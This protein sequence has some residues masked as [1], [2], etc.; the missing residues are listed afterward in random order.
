MTV[1]E[2]LVQLQGADPN[3]IVVV[4]EGKY[5]YKVA[6][7]VTPGYFTGMAGDWQPDD[8]EVGGTNSVCIA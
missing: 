5:G 7:N 6:R 3:A 1:A 2:I 8:E 4:H